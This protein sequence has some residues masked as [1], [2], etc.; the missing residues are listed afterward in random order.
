[1]DLTGKFNHCSASGHEYLIVEYNY[2]ANAI[3]VEPIKNRLA[4]TIADGRISIKNSQQQ[5]FN[6]THMC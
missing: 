2:Y 6:P 3:L 5:D 4:N 1:M